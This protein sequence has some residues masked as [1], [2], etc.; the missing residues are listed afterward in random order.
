MSLHKLAVLAAS[1][2]DI[3]HKASLE[4][5]ES[6]CDLC[7]I[8]IASPLDAQDAETP[9][10]HISLFGFGMEGSTHRRL[11]KPRLLHSHV[12]AQWMHHALETATDR[13]RI[14]SGSE[15]WPHELQRIV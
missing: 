2:E 15:D 7:G 5:P 10:M 8:F 14:W 13:S 6:I 3:V 11:T 12:V 1:I 9:L 4:H